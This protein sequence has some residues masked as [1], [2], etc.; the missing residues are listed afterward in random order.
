MIILVHSIVLSYSAVILTK[1]NYHIIPHMK[2][3]EDF[4]TV[5]SVELLGVALRGC[6]WRNLSA[7]ESY[8]CFRNKY[9]SRSKIRA[10]IERRGKQREFLFIR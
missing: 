8:A 6:R 2:C 5:V 3:F 4:W 9:V 10:Q 7:Y 1:I